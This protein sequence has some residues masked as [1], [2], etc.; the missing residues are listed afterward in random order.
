MGVQN[1]LLSQKSKF[2]PI[3]CKMQDKIVECVL[4]TSRTCIVWEKAWGALGVHRGQTA[5]ILSS[6]QVMSVVLK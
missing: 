4:N 5:L 1:V 6:F 2:N 3:F